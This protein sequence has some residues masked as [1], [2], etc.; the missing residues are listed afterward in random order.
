MFFM[1][2]SLCLCHT[3]IA[4]S[5]PIKC[6]Y[7][8]CILFLAYM[9][10]VIDQIVIDQTFFLR[11][12]CIHVVRQGRFFPRKTSMSA[13]PGLRLARR[14]LTISPA[15]EKIRSDGTDVAGIERYLMA[16]FFNCGYRSP[17]AAHQST[18]LL[19][20]SAQTRSSK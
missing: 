12:H 11:L 20:T 17:L 18:G 4:N 14:L 2:T 15:L 7:N 5:L 13:V 9:S 10:H 19:L 6:F 3:Q 16:S 1:P 8:A